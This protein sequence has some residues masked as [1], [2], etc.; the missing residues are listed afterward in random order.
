[1]N[2]KKNK[3]KNKYWA[4]FRNNYPLMLGHS[5][6]LIYATII[7]VSFFSFVNEFLRTIDEPY[8]QVLGLIILLFS[9][10]RLINWIG[11]D[12][13]HNWAKSME[14]AFTRDYYKGLKK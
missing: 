10:F 12:L 6:A 14:D 5:V 11:F 3:N 8:G 13:L 4:S 9:M 2:K 7:F 1:M